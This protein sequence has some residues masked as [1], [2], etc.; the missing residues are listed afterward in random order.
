MIEPS[1]EAVAELSKLRRRDLLSI[2]KRLGR[3][4]SRSW[5]RWFAAVGLALFGAVIG[6]GFG[7][8]PFLGADP[9]PSDT[10]KIAYFALMLIALI[11]AVVCGLAT[12]ATEDERADSIA[13][14]KEDL[15]DLLGA[16]KS[17]GSEET[18]SA[19]GS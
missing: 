14:I 15:D 11:L 4:K 19:R 13:A 7:L 12:L 2:S 8:I 10:G 1:P 9:G 16:Y 3:L 5:G 17:T 6:G 18:A